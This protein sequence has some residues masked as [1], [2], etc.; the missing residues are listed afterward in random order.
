MNDNELFFSKIKTVITDK[1]TDTSVLPISAPR[2][3]TDTGNIQAMLNTVLCEQQ[4]GYVLVAVSSESFRDILLS[5]NR[6]LPRYKL[7]VYCDGVFYAKEAIA[8]MLRE[9]RLLHSAGG[10]EHYPEKQAVEN[11]PIYTDENGLV[12]IQG[13]SDGE[14][15]YSADGEFWGC[16]PRGAL[17]TAEALR[18]RLTEATG[19]LDLNTK[20]NICLKLLDLAEG[21]ALPEPDKLIM[22]TD[23]SDAE[24]LGV[25]EPV[26]YSP[27]AL[28][29]LLYQVYFG[30]ETDR[31]DKLAMLIEDR[32]KSP[33]IPAYLFEDFTTAFAPQIFPSTSGR[34]TPPD[35]AQF[36]NT[37]QRLL[38]GA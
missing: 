17:F 18:G 28:A 27:R 23:G 8:E 20:A 26:Q 10:A 12:L 11:M 24:L 36:R 33:N 30:H 4:S 32:L 13:S 6:E 7:S 34:I 5:L 3:E 29:K 21:N 15:L 2:V 37:A 1:V 31:K 22:F 9:E 35:T 19:G 16:V 38:I 14:A 25:G